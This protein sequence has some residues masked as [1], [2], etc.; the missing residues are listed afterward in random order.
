MKKIKLKKVL[1]VMCALY[2]TTRR[3]HLPWPR[4][5]SW[6]EF[7]AEYHFGRPSAE[8]LY[9][10]LFLEAQAAIAAY[11]GETITAGFDYK[12]AKKR[13]K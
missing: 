6:N 8:I 13:V 1:D 5:L 3:E 4:C 11:E 2:V 9:G 7:L 12:E 10:N